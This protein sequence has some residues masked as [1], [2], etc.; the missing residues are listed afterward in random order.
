MCKASVQG[1]RARQACKAGIAS[2][3]DEGLF[4]SSHWLLPCTNP[5]GNDN[6]WGW[7]LGD[8]S[9]Q[10]E[11]ARREELHMGMG[12]CSAAIIGFSGLYVWW[13]KTGG[14]KWAWGVRSM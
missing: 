2:Y 7:G 1:K 8:V 3:G 10:G 6:G 5:R 9:V 4:C 14:E 13:Y 12:V 11:C